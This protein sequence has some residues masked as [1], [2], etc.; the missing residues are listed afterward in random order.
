LTGGWPSVFFLK[1]E[2]D[3]LPFTPDMKEIFVLSIF[4]PFAMICSCQKQ[5]S[6]AEQQLTQRKVELDEREKA[7]DEREKALAQREKAATTSRKLPA[8]AQLPSRTPDVAQL[9]AERDKRIQERLAQ[10]Q[11]R[12]EELQKTRIP[13]KIVPRSA[14]ATSPTPS[15]AVE[16][17]SP[18]PSPT[19]E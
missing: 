2:Q 19:P 17:T 13:L 4:V 12:I 3:E 16:A 18:S 5:D 1:I 11:R 6:T 9:K 15:P 10:R 7:L 14:E 8:N